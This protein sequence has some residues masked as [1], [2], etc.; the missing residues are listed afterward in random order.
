MFDYYVLKPCAWHTS[1]HDSSASIHVRGHQ[2]AHLPE[3][4]THP[5]KVK[6]CRVLLAL[7]LRPDITYL[8]FNFK[9]MIFIKIS[10]TYIYIYTSLQLSTIMGERIHSPGRHREPERRPIH[11]IQLHCS[12]FSSILDSNCAASGGLL[13]TSTGHL[14]TCWNWN[15][16]PCFCLQYLKWEKWKSR[17]K[18]KLMIS[19]SVIDV[20]CLPLTSSGVRKFLTWVTVEVHEHTLPAFCIDCD[21]DDLTTF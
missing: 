13:W 1:L 19:F 7:T 11:A 5:S 2:K 14:V 21:W 10:H 8:A 3:R 12:I 15:R 18:S 20:V 16:P 4:S 17:T 9:W 6:E